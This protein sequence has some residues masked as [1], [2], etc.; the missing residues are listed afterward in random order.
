MNRRRLFRNLFAL[1]V[2]AALPLAVN[3]LPAAPAAAPDDWD[4]FIARVRS[5]VAQIVRREG[6]GL[7]RMCIDPPRISL[8]ATFYTRRVRI[9]LEA[10]GSLLQKV[11]FEWDEPYCSRW[12]GDDL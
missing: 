10:G 7:H 5:R 4:D 3:V 6:R 12:N 8:D 2:V 9:H 11:Y 1:G